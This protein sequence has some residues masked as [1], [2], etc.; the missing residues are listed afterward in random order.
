MGLAGPVTASRRRVARLTGF[1]A[2]SIAATAAQRAA[3]QQEVRALRREIE[4]RFDVLILRE[5]LLLRPKAA[6]SGVN[7]IEVTGDAISIDGAPVTGGELRQK[8]GADGDLVI[9]LSYLDS[10]SRRSMFGQ[11]ESVAPPPPPPPPVIE[12]RRFGHRRGDRV[13]IGSSVSVSDDESISG[14]V[15]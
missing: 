1:A 5:G 8:L 3:D 2:L 7:A 12:R 4:R 9:Q 10:A 6:I 15:V 13:Q 14:D 11:V